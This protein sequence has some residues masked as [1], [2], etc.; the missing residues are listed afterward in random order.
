MSL[1]LRVTAVCWLVSVVVLVVW[2]FASAS[3][4]PLAV[5]AAFTTAWAII[6]LGSHFIG[7]QGWDDAREP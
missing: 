2:A 1:L 6:A 7:G 4:L 3:S 5:A